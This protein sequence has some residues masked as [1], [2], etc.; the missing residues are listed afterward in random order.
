MLTLVYTGGAI[1]AS[2]RVRYDDL[3]AKGFDEKLLAERLLRQHKLICAAI[4]SGRIEDLKKMTERESPSR[5]THAKDGKPADSKPL[6]EP[7][8]TFDPEV[9]LESFKSTPSPAPRKEQ[10][11]PLGPK[12]P[13]RHKQP[14]TTANRQPIAIRLGQSANAALHVV[15]I[16]EKLYRGG[17]RVVLRVRVENAADER[18]TIPGAD[19]IV[20]ILGSTF[21]PMIFQTRT[22]TDGIA[23]VDTELP[24]F[25]S[26]RAAILV[27]A[28]AGDLEAELRRIIQ[29]G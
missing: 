12:V 25:R 15:L 6:V 3:I 21:R 9:T 17:D 8:A 23:A 16:D 13:P 2:K 22:G 5:A 10:T 19:V 4:R 27:R 29:Q 7:T 26:G 18:E 24:H 14:A 11:S 28:T 20:K 1:L